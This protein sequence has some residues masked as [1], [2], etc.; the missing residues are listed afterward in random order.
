M[1]VRIR[2]SFLGGNILQPDQ[3]DHL[4][5]RPPSLQPA[6][7]VGQARH[8]AGSS[9]EWRTRAS[10]T[11][12]RCRCC[13]SG[14]AG[15]APA[16]AS[17]GV[18]VSFAEINNIAVLGEESFAS[19]DAVPELSF[20][21]HFFQDLVESSIFY[22]AL[23]PERKDTL[24]NRRLLRS[25]PNLF[26]QVAGRHGRYRGRGEGV[27]E[28]AGGLHLMADIVSTRNWCCSARSACA[29]TRRAELALRPFVPCAVKEI[30]TVSAY[31]HASLNSSSGCC[32]LIA[33]SGLLQAVSHLDHAARGTSS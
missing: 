13:C 12:R 27:P 25:F 6:R 16:T 20:G 21:T 30:T 2:G 23:Y 17:L 10:A 3:P 5:S 26:R 7:R 28:P 9:A 1:L 24:F 22:F 15:G 19:A 31:L 18:P 32:T 29:Y 33:L 14:R 11:A 8:P 4:T